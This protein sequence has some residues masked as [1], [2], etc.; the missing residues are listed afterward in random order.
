MSMSTVGP[1]ETTRRTFGWLD[2]LEPQS[3]PTAWSRRYESRHSNQARGPLGQL[4]DEDLHLLDREI[5]G[6]TDALSVLR[7]DR[8]VAR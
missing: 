3:S 4:A 2:S 1:E 5:Q 8:G 6:E 7:F